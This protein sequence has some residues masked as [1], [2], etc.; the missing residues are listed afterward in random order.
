MTFVAYWSRISFRRHW[1]SLVG[2][3]AL[4]GLIGGLSLF[5]VAGAR[6]TQSAYP[7]FLRSTNPSTIAVDIGGQDPDQTRETIDTL[8]RLPE[9]AQARAYTGFLIA[10]LVD[11]RPDLTKDFEALGS[12]DGRYFA[13]DRFT[14]T[15][16]RLPD[17]NRVDEV[18]IN[19]E[20]ARRYGYHLG[21]KLDL[22]TVSEEQAE[23]PTFL[24]NP[25]PK[26]RMTATIVGVGLFIEEVVQDDTDRS[27][28][29]LLTPAYVAQARELGTYSWLGLVLRHGDT[30]VDGVKAAV[31]RGSGSSSPQIF[32]AT[33]ID[34]F[35]AEQ[36][37]R[38]VS[39]ALGVFGAI[40][41]AAAVV[42][43]ALALGRQI[44]AER[45]DRVIARAMG[46]SPR[47][48]A[49]AACIPSAS[50]LVAGLA[51][52]MTVAALASPAMPIGPV[53]RVEVQRGFSIDMTVLALGGLCLLAVLLLILGVLAWREASEPVRRHASAQSL[54][55][56]MLDSATSWLPVS[57]STGLRLAFEPG[58]GATAAPVRSV[59]AGAAIA[60]AALVA[61]ITFGASLTHLTDRPRL[62]GWD[63]DLALVAG[64]GYG[65]TKPAETAAVLGQDH[66][67]VAWGG[68]FYGADQIDGRTVPLLGMDRTSS[69]TPP[70]RDGRMIQGPGEIV[71]GT[72]TVVQLHK[73]IGESVTSTSGPLRIVGTTTLPTLGQV[74]GDHTSLGIGGIIDTRSVPG[75][76]RNQATAT[77]N[78]EVSRG[79]SAAD[80][81]PNVLFV[82]L[83]KGVDRTAVM[84]RL[85]GAADRI[86]GPQ[87]LEVKS[88][89]RPA[90]I[91]NTDDIGGA[92]TL[93]GI[94]VALAALAA[95]ASALVAGVR[96]R[97]HD[98]ALL[99]S[100]G[101]TRGQLSST[102]AWQATGIMAV[103]IVVGLPLGVIAG[104][105]MWQRFATALDVLAEPAVPLAAVGLV[106]LASVIA[107]NVV[108][109][110][111]ARYARSVPAAL[112]L[113]NE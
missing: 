21:Q 32:R 105:L 9:V 38:P 81:G 89:Q 45:D 112:L 58:E 103:A 77:P 86:G 4:V 17:V 106:V 90:E 52:A 53:R 6:R 37:V 101:F 73:R 78:G 76:D 108:S 5:A 85:K 25:V 99:K 48:L 79:V 66:D 54:P 110:F 15:A 69:V 93:L 111:P 84:K 8:S 50:A 31:R 39:V 34:T 44:Q 1:R 98:L 96:R 24:D 83:R 92:P 41:A 60:V 82:R 88:V 35:H 7:R 74:H 67:I 28:L 104:R 46:A 80:Y 51:L 16:G 26:L 30:D 12:V 62:F 57:A 70:I 95:L 36:A 75:F 11:G 113:R 109:A 63:W 100:L 22:A 40:A 3:A 27:T 72:A 61:A 18:A 20:T 64:G 19:E 59:M 55:P 68:A 94:A 10:P 49:V 87:G 91:V 47:R 56:R 13:Q 65:N 107:A 29:M 23:D 42:L 102:I 33:S 71:L 2:I 14:P 97:R 43:V